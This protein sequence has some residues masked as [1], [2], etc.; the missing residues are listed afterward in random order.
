MLKYV[1]EFKFSATLG[2]LFKIFEAALEDV[3]QEW[4][5]QQI[6]RFET[7]KTDMDVINVLKDIVPTYHPNHNV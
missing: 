7:C 2:F 6:K 3:D 1:K 4:L 5:G